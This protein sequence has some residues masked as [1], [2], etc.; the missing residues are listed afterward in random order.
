MCLPVVINAIWIGPELGQVQAACLR[1]FLR[2]GHRVVL[3]CYERPKDTPA[4][5]EIAD[6]TRL[7]PETRII[8]HATG[9]LSLFAD[10]LRYE[11]L[12]AGMGL[13]VDC[14]VFCLRP[15]ED[16]DYIFG[17]ENS[18]RINSAVLK[19]PANCPVLAEL[20]AIKNSP[21]FA[22]PWKQRKPADIIGWLKGK[23]SAK[24][25]EDR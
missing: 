11:I 5:V 8:R 24:A 16:A 2:H 18:D 10:L 3:H 9:S 15:I 25:L 4:G 21:V 20:R 13:Y 12:G 23:R 7:L 1:S 6:A 17:L 22:P 19:L 14:D